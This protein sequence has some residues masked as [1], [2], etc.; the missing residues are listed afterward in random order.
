MAGAIDL[1]VQKINLYGIETIRR[2]ILSLSQKVFLSRLNG[3]GENIEIVKM[4]INR[5]IITPIYYAC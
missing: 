1:S 2:G 5:T 4:I 3:C